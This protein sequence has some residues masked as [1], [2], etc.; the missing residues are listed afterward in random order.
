[1]LRWGLAPRWGKLKGGPAL[2]QARDDKLASSNAWKPFARTAE[3]RC[4][5]VADGWIEWQRPEDPKQTKQ[6]FLHR[7]TDGDLFAFAGLWTVAQPKDADE[8]I[9]SCA[10][11]TT[12]ANRDVAFVNHRMPVVLDGPDAE[13]A[14]LDPS[15]DLEAAVELAAPLADGRLDVYPISPRVNSSRNEGLDCS[16]AWNPRGRHERAAL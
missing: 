1:M 10:V 15:V 11:V 2:F 4:L 14:W 13:R 12:A 7:L 8:P 3:H 9:A 5:M 16:S 6:P